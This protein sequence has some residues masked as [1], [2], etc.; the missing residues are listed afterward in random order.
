MDGR[1]KPAS[2]KVEYTRHG[3]H[4]KNELQRN[5]SFVTITTADGS[6]T[7]Y[8]PVKELGRGKY[9]KVTL[10]SNGLHHFVVKKPLRQTRCLK[11]EAAIAAIADSAD[12]E[13]QFTK[14]AYPQ[15]KP[16]SFIKYKAKN[17]DPDLH[18]FEYRML[19]P[20]VDGI[21]LFD[22][23]LSQPDP[24]ILLLTFYNIAKELKRIHDLGIIHGDISCNNIM[25][26]NPYKIRLI[27]FA[28]AYKIGGD[29]TLAEIGK[30]KPTY[31]APERLHHK[32][33][34]ADF[35]Q[36]VFSLAST[37][38]GVCHNAMEFKERLKLFDKYPALQN[39][40]TQGQSP[41]PNDRPLLQDFINQIGA[42][43]YLP[44]L[45]SA[46]MKSEEDVGELFK[47]DEYHYSLNEFFIVLLDF[48]QSGH[49]TAGKRLFDVIFNSHMIE[50]NEQ[51]LTIELFSL[52]LEFL[53]KVPKAYYPNLLNLELNQFLFSTL[54]LGLQLLD[55]LV[56][57]EIKIIPPTLSAKLNSN[58]A[59][60]DIFQRMS[61]T[62]LIATTQNTADKLDNLL[63]SCSIM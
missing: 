19:L 36:D 33:C 31:F 47:S 41:N 4:S 20:F 59:L 25:V 58:R 34:V 2:V 49:L 61:E 13:F 3:R 44:K 30:D 10:F 42:A 35:N 8:K 56:R 9:G 38:Y 53:E 39:F 32:K 18:Y 15:K 63:T 14:L 12:R 21:T 11:N 24:D 46:L 52:I 5:D 27:D 37:L 26:K 55:I 50:T 7:A 54:T 57:A 1:N 17:T 62:N 51:K 6:R 60:S 22:L 48:C 28:F 40:I 43:L 45:K 29:A 16:Y 23:A